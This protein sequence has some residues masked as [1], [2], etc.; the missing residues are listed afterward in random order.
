MGW[1]GEVFKDLI[2]TNLDSRLRG[3]DS[4]YWI[5]DQARDDKTKKR[6]EA[7]YINNLYS[8]HL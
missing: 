2:N 6:A 5:P 8:L 4:K 1:S 3:N 7:R